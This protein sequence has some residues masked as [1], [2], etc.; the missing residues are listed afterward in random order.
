GMG[1]GLPADLGH[2]QDGSVGVHTPQLLCDL[3]GRRSRSRAAD[4][5]DGR[6][7]HPHG[8]RLSALRLG[9]SPYRRKYPRAKGY[10]R[11]AKEQDPGRERGALAAA[12]VA[13]P[14]CRFASSFCWV[15]R[16]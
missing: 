8:E 10:Y 6:R 4:L 14:P 2:A 15:W 16:L 9:V 1:E 5:R 12:L 13:A 11:A 3:R 7:S